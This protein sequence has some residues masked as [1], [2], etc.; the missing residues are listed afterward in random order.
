MAA[1]EDVVKPATTA[2]NI[3]GVVTGGEVIPE[4]YRRPYEE[5][6]YE[7]PAFDGRKKDIPDAGR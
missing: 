2:F 6:P 3:Y 1:Y 5:G 7:D 4:V